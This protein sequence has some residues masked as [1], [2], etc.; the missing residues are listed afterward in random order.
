MQSSEIENKRDREL[1]RN[2]GR[3]R[4]KDCNKATVIQIDMVANYKKRESKDLSKAETEAETRQRVTSTMRFQ[5]KHDWES[6]YP[7][8]ILLRQFLR[9]WCQ[10]RRWG[11]WCHHGK[12]LM[13]RSLWRSPRVHHGIFLDECLQQ[14]HHLKVNFFDLID[15]TERTK[16]KKIPI[17]NT[18][19][20]NIGIP[21]P[22][23]GIRFILF[24]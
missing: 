14:S 11:L 17:L 12:K 19:L 6:I 2:I 16:T 8:A 22:T 15:D 21:P 13:L 23:C 5:T 24:L 9:C 4:E 1:G 20:Q 7:E 10:T 3:R 18:S